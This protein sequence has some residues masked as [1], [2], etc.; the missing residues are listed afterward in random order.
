MNKE[1]F[2]NIIN[3]VLDSTLR[4]LEEAKKRYEFFESTMDKMSFNRVIQEAKG[5][6]IILESRKYRLQ[7]L[8][9]LPIYA[10]IQAMSELEIEEYKKEK[11]EELATQAKVVK[12]KEA[13]EKLDKE[14]LIIERENLI[15][16]LDSLTL[17]E[18][19]KA[20]ERGKE[21][22]KILIQYD[23]QYSS[24]PFVKI[25]NELRVIEEQQEEIKRKSSKQIKEELCSKIENIDHIKLILDTF[26][27]NNGPYE[28]DSF[29]RLKASVAD[30]PEKA[31]KMANLL[32]YYIRIC[33][34]KKSSS[35]HI[36]YARTTLPREL[37]DK[38]NEIRLLSSNERF[39]WRMEEFKLIVTSSNI[40]K[41]EETIKVAEER[42]KSEKERLSKEYTY[43]KLK[44]F[45][46]DQDVNNKVD[47]EF[48]KIHSDKIEKEQTKMLQALSE[49]KES[50]SNKFFKTWKT[51]ESIFNLDY[52][53]S[54][55]KKKIYNQVEGWY[56]TQNSSVVGPNS[57][58]QYYGT[59]DSKESRMTIKADIERFYQ[60]MSKAESGIASLKE[61]IGRLNDQIVI[62]N[63]I[64][65]DRKDKTR[66]EIRELAGPEFAKTE[67]SELGFSSPNYNQI[68]T[69]AGASSDVIQ[70][71]LV[72]N[73]LEE[74]K[75]QSNEK[76]AELRNVSI[77]ELIRLRNE[78][79]EKNNTQKKEETI[80]ETEFFSDISENK[81]SM[82]DGIAR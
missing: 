76:E 20:I 48:I 22:N 63:K 7:K 29:T 59:W 37:F 66:D 23:A 26:E 33:Q 44:Y 42:F 69:I 11:I 51:K 72:S 4:D 6:I 34:E 10:R 60:D 28:S 46:L 70:M 32:D 43:E 68:E 27:K 50:L 77:E 31:L 53:I 56:Q 80:T 74:A 17:S 39:L 73:V 55:I 14:N 36:L 65:Q 21:I 5:R 49:Q 58:F 38:L 71:D 82:E 15:K 45:E 47:S 81:T 78:L 64:I 54:E 67:I 9:N 2:A 24:N 13:Q 41:I 12:A 3:N 75:K 8:V 62:E 40:D 1:E 25:E 57:K 30:D 79:S 18:R 16:S 61:Q 52:Q 19:E 35:E